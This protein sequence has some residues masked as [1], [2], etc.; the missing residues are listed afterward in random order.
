MSNG[1]PHATDDIQAA[2]RLNG[3]QRRLDNHPSIELN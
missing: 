3:A 1:A 2:S